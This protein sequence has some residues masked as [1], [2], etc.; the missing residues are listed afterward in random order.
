MTLYI[1]STFGIEGDAY[2]FIPYS[3]GSHY[4]QPCRSRGCIHLLSLDSL[5]EALA[6][7]ICNLLNYV[8]V[9]QD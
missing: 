9:L 6:S 1:V 8:V 7:S 2:G 5:S 4:S 3:Y